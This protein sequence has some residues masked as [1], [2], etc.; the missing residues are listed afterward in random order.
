MK[1]K[2]TQKER[3]IELRKQGKTYSEILKRVPVAKST[4][5]L[6][7]RDVGLAKAQKQRISKKRHE[8]QM[9]GAKARKDQRIQLTRD[10]YASAEK[11]IKCISKRELWLMGVMLY[12]AEGSKEKPWH[13][14]SGVQFSNSDPR[15][16][17][18]FLEWLS[19]YGTKKGDVIFKLF[20]HENHKDNVEKV[21]LYWARETGFP[22][23]HFKYVYFKKHN[24]KTKRR[25]TEEGYHGNLVVVVKKS[26]EIVRKIE[27]WA[28]GIDKYYEK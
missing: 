8:A 15:M 2:T 14:G 9:R 27:G 28:R 12:W 5:S 17:R 25:N 3:A 7:L 22:R 1:T 20:I 21:F 18:L 24:P 6:W 23:K 4:L 13:S 26:S 16:I 10:I 19:L 11:D